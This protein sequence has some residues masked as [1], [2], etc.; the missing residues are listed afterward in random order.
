MNFKQGGRKDPSKNCS[1]LLNHSYYAELLA[2]TDEGKGSFDMF[3]LMT[4]LYPKPNKWS[5]KEI[6]IV[7][8]LNYQF[9]LNDMK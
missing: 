9:Q 7:F 3:H 4:I 5:F 8:K 2:K 1:D 6:I